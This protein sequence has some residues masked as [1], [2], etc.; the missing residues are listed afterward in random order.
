MALIPWCGGGCVG[1]RS[2]GRQVLARL[3]R[4]VHDVAGASAAARKHGDAHGT[5]AGSANNRDRP[6]ASKSDQLR[7]QRH[8]WRR[9]PLRA[10]RRSQARLQPRHPRHRRHR[11]TSRTRRSSSTRSAC[12]GSPATKATMSKERL[13]GGR[14]IDCGRGAARRCAG[15]HVLPV[16]GGRDVYQGSL[17]EDRAQPGPVRRPIS[18]CPAACWC[19][20]GPSG[21][22]WCCS[23]SPRI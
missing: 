2:G 3:L 6:N 11:R 7:R 14:H 1:R 23:R 18:M 19:C 12:S 10:I 21:I 20:D 17:S 16:A 13:T 8:R 22:G 9:L 15:G 5:A 4:H